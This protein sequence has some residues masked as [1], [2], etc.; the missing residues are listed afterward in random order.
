[1]S[2]V[3][4][5]LVIRGQV[6]VSKEVQISELWKDP[7]HEGLGRSSEEKHQEGI[8]QREVKKY[9]RKNCYH[10]IKCSVANHLV[11]LMWR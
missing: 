5:H 1:M 10:D 8:R 9:L 7:D 4:G 11:T 6:D 3:R 2:L